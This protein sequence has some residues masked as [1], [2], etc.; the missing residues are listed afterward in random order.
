MPAIQYCGKQKQRNQPLGL[1][2]QPVHSGGVPGTVREHVL[3]NK[4]EWIKKDPS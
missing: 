3:N 2:D 4:V 1:A